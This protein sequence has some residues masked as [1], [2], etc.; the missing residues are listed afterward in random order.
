MTKL[1]WEGCL[2]RASVSQA[3]FKSSQIPC[4]G[5]KQW[6]DEIASKAKTGRRPCHE[7]G[8]RNTTKLWGKIE[9]HGQEGRDISLRGLLG[10]SEQ[11]YP[12]PQNAVFCR[13][14][15]DGRP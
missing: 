7:G 14:A 3:S 6:S 1:F 15:G 2:L 13:V 4:K 9:E 5:Y 12:P 10:Q 11:P 8:P